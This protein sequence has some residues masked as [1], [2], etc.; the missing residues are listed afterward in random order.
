VFQDVTLVVAEIGDC[1]VDTTVTVDELIRCVS[2]ALGEQP[3]EGCR[4]CDGNGDAEVTVDE[5][6][7][8]VNAA[9]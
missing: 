5:L 2:I 4:A 6:L 9:L 7:R 8:G 3:V 1:N